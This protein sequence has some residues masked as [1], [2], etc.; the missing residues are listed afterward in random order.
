MTRLHDK[1]NIQVK[2]I[3]KAPFNGLRISPHLFNTE[4]DIDSLVAALRAELK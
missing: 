2:V 3:E 4:S 1:Y